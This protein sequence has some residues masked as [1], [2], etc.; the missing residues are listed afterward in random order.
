ML[1]FRVTQKLAA[2]LKIAPTPPL[3]DWTANHFVADRMN[4]PAGR[5]PPDAFLFVQA[6]TKRKQKRPVSCGG[7][8]CRRAS[9]DQLS[10]NPLTSTAL[11]GTEGGARFLCGPQRRLIP[12]S[13]RN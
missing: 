1:I 2:K 12:T 8:L 9:S 13:S 4:Q 3:T 11:T 10:I 5:V 7:H 6:A